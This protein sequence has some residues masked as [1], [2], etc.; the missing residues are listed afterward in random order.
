MLTEDVYHHLILVH[1]FLPVHVLV[2]R[3]KIV[4]VHQLLH[5]LTN[6]NILLPD[7][8]IHLVLE[9][10]AEVVVIH[11]HHHPEVAVQALIALHP[12][13]EPVPVAPL[14]EVAV[15]VPALVAVVAVDVI[16][17]EIEPFI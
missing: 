8:V 10:R 6:V 3:E 15:Q 9:Q 16:G 2:F 1:L 5:G 11:L 12:E 14:V 7:Q 4:L 13:V 17:N